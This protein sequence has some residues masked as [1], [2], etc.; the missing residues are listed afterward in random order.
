MCAD[1]SRI[2]RL[3]LTKTGCQASIAVSESA[4]RTAS[5]ADRLQ[6]MAAVWRRRGRV[7]PLLC[8][9]RPRRASARL[10]HPRARPHRPCAA[11][12]A[13]LAS[14]SPQH[15]LR[16]PATPLPS[17]LLRRDHQRSPPFHSP[18]SRARSSVSTFS[19]VSTLQRPHLCP[20]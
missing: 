6:A 9:A 13:F 11:H 16:A 7:S 5:V 15:S 17:Q 8:P 4:D 1:S 2:Q 10:Q 14:P 19:T 20:R 12:F 3:S 18:I